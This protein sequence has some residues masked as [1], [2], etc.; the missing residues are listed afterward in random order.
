MPR[1]NDDLNSEFSTFVEPDTTPQAGGPT[2]PT[3]ISCIRHRAEPP[4]T[5][6]TSRRNSHLHATYGSNLPASPDL[7]QLLT[8]KRPSSALILLS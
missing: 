6:R 2:I 8:P 3:I 5:L 4:S 7:G 1:E